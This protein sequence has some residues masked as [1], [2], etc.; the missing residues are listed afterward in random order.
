M[1]YQAKMILQGLKSSV[2]ELERSCKG[3]KYYQQIV[4]KLNARVEFLE[5]HLNSNHRYEKQIYTIADCYRKAAESLQSDN[6]ELAGAAEQLIAQGHPD[7]GTMFSVAKKFIDQ[8]ENNWSVKTIK[9]EGGEPV[10]QYKLQEVK[11][12][13]LLGRLGQRFGN[14]LTRPRQLNFYLRRMQK[15]ELQI[16]LLLKDDKPFG[17][18]SLHPRSR[19]IC[20]FDLV[21]GSNSFKLPYSLAMEILNKLDANADCTPEFA[22]VG[23]FDVFK[24]APPIV[25]PAVVGEKLIWV[26]RFENEII[27]ALKDRNRIGAEMSWSRFFRTKEETRTEFEGEWEDTMG[28][29]LKL[30][31][32][33][34]LLMQHP[35]LIQQLSGPILEDSR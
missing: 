29:N 34:S 19:A 27:I 22:S 8:Y 14:C 16:W 30:G 11:S 28:I 4:E 18:L 25:K 20:D 7:I 1:S 24:K 6:S 13:S 32:L 17:L 15:G 5:V 9:L 31:D 2:A 35:E 26:W 21:D 3:R 23:A 10:G 12:K 33:L